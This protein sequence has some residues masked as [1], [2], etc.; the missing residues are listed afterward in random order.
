MLE[1]P[2]AGRR[3]LGGFSSRCVGR[4]PHFTIDNDAVHGL[5]AAPEPD[6][7]LCETFEIS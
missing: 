5:R 7:T 1:L 3:F 2:G 4:D 6:A